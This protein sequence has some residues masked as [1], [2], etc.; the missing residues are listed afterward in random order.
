MPARS[1]EARIK[2]LGPLNNMTSTTIHKGMI[3]VLSSSAI[4][5]SISSSSTMTLSAPYFL[6]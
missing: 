2:G 4:G 3:E 5:V 1:I 6:S